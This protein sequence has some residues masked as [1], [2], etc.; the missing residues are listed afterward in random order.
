MPEFVKLINEDTK[1]FDFH[2]N[3]AKRIIQPGEDVIVPWNVACTLLGNPNIPDIAP[4]NE[5]TRMYKKLRQRYNFGDGLM[6]EDVWE[7]KRPK[8]RVFDIEDDRQVIMLIDD[9]DGDHLGAFNPNKGA[10]NKQTDMDALQKQVAA[11]T[12]QLERLAG[13]AQSAPSEPA[14][15]NTDSPTAVADGPGEVSI[16]DVFNIPTAGE[17]DIATAD[18]PQAVTVGEDA[19]PPDNTAAKKAPAKKVAAKKVAAQK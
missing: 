9:P 17:D 2:Q 4:A 18:S 3:N 8:L 14:S 16:D 6:Q 13:N 10:I 19:P 5:R 11:L 7:S 15:G 1:P 12:K